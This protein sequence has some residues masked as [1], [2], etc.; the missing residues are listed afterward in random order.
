[1]RRGSSSRC[2]AAGSNVAAAARQQAERMR[3]IGIL[4]PF[5]A[6]HWK[7]APR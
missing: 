1:M 4:M 3:R 6:D 5:A 7:D 2:W